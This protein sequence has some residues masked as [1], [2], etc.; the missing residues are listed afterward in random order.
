[1]ITNPKLKTVL[2]CNLAKNALRIKSLSSSDDDA[3]DKENRRLR[4]SW[5][6]PMR[7]ALIMNIKK[8]SIEITMCCVNMLPKSNC[9]SL[10]VAFL[11]RT[12][13]GIVIRLL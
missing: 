7:N 1:M 12:A 6:V 3:I 5:S 8:V 2:T 4:K 13:N 10:S 9:I 11:L